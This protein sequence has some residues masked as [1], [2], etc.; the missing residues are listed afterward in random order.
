MA[1]FRLTMAQLQTF[2][3]YVWHRGTNSCLTLFKFMVPISIIIRF[4]QQWGLLTYICDY[5]EPVMQIVGLPAETAIVWLTT[6]VVNIYGGFLTLFSIYPQMEPMTVAQ[7]TT[8][9]TMMLVAHTFPIEITIAQKTGVKAWVMTAIRFVFA[10]LLGILMS[11][12]YNALGALQDEATISPF[13]TTTQTSWGAWALNELKN[14][15]IIT[16]VIFT[17]VI[18]LHL[19]DVTGLIR[20]VNKVME[21]TLKWLGISQKVLPITIIGLTL[22]IAYGGGL[23]IEESR[24]KDIDIKGIFYSMTLM[25]LFHSIIEDTLLMLSMG[26]HW[27]GVVLFR[28]V[29]ACIITFIFVKCTNRMPLDKFER[30][31]MTK[32]VKNR[33]KAV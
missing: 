8:L 9:F 20:I 16:C 15:A 25:G 32:A 10:I 21:P 1:Q 3:D 2:F 14:Y 24:Q 6:M 13:L 22:G 31:F 23:L 4:I 28:F 26:G 30:L 17:L 18:F 5:L 7:M 11:R 12:M 27:T 19:L 33:E 29:Y